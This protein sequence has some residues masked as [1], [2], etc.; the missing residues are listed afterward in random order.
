MIL[1]GF[2]I[3]GFWGAAGGGA[4]TGAGAG[5][6][7]TVGGR[8]FSFEAPA[9]WK[10]A[11]AERRVTATHDSEL[12]QVATFPLLK[13]YDARL[14]GRVAVELR[15]RMREIAGQTNGHL[16]RE[17]TVTADG[18]RS[19]AYDVTVGD[20]ID[21]Y[22]FLLNGKREYLLLCRRSSEDRAAACSR[23][24]TSFSRA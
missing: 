15:S 2:C 13:P 1:A 17:R 24:V 22:T 23:L 16:S 19:H 12:V 5:D 3:A 6:W 4:H 14:F 9:G 18:V 8:G 11:R 21:E 20:H 10:V 7:Q